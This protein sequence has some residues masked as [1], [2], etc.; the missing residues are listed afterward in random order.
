MIF[1]C[2]SSGVNAKKHGKGGGGVRG[3]ANQGWTSSTGSR[4][5]RARPGTTQQNP[6]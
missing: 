6:R 4:S 2:F 3:S 1:F 5:G